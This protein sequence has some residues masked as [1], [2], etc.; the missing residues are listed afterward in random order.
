MNF[1]EIDLESTEYKLNLNIVLPKGRGKDVKIGIFADGDMNVRAKKVSDYVLSKAEVE[2]YSR[3]KLVFGALQVY[4]LEVHGKLYAL[5][6]FS[7]AR[8]GFCLLDLLGYVF[9]VHFPPTRNFLRNT[10]GSARN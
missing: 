9:F 10:R 8:F 7:L 1:K 3:N 2:E 5:L 4:L 6:E